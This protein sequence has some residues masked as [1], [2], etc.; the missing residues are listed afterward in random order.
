MT[1]RRRPRPGWDGGTYRAWRDGDDVAVIMSTVWDTPKDAQEFS[2]ALRT[3]VSEGSL[4]GLVLEA[5]GTTVHA[6]F[7]SAEPLMGAVSSI[8]RSL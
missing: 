5:D 7:A 8:L 2:Q 6:G 3:W 4:P 1:R